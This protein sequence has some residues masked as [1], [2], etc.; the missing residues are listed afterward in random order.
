MMIGTASTTYPRIEGSRH[1][2]Y[3]MCYKML[4]IHRLSE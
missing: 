4:D 1:L 3:S 2:L